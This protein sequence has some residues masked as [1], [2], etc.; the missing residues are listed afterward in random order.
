MICLKIKKV[1]IILWV[2][3]LFT[4]KLFY[5]NK[6]SNC[7]LTIHDNIFHKNSFCQ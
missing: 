1:N 4:L 2:L 6:S 5:I 7:Y 3:F